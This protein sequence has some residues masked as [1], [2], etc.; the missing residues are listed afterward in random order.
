MSFVR[1]DRLPWRLAALAL[2]ACLALSGCRKEEIPAATPESTT[3]RN[4]H[5]RDR[6]AGDVPHPGGC[7]HRPDRRGAGRNP[8]RRPQLCG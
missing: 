5:R 7:R 6:R 4:R 1:F 3:P 2:T 8:R